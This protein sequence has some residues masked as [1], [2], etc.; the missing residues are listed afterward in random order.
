LVARY[1]AAE[2]ASIDQLEAK[3][4]AM[5]STL[6][7]L[8][9]EHGG[10]DGLLFEVQNDKGKITKGALTTR[11]KEIGGDGEADEERQLLLEYQ[12]Q[13]D[14]KAT[15]E[16]QART[17]TTALTKK[18]AAKYG[19]LC[20]DEIKTLVVEDK[21]LA[22]L[23]ASVR[24]EVD[25]VSQALARRVAELADR[26]ATPLPRQ[27]EEVARLSARVDEHLRRMGATWT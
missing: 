1:F 21:W 14:K 6:E 5:A 17:A 25:R 3:A 22:I 13:Q 24:G 26:Y 10:E 7:E 11:L 16:R 15:L 23:E 12:S 20:Q 19:A 9:E 8:V 27:V 18:V 4:A 2:R